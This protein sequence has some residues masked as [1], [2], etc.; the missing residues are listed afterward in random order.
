MGSKQ[1]LLTLAVVLVAVFSLFNG[2]G[3]TKQWPQSLLSA[4]FNFLSQNATA[5]P[6]SYIRDSFSYTGDASANKAVNQEPLNIVLLYADDWTMKVLGKLNPQVLTPNID[7]MADKGI[8]FTQNCVTTS[9]CWVSRAT[10]MTGLYAVRHGQ[11]KLK[12]DHIFK[13]HPWSQTLFPLLRNEGYYTGL[14]GKWHGLKPDKYMKKAFDFQVLYHGTHWMKRNG[15]TRHVTDLNLEDSMKFLK[16][17]PKDKKFA[18]K[19]SFFA[20]H[21]EKPGIFPSYQPMKSNR[22]E[23]TTIPFP[24]T[25]TDRHWKD[26][27]NFFTKSNEGRK[28][29]QKRFEHKHYNESIK[30]LYKMAS[31]VDDV[32][33]KII[34]E[35]KDQGVYDSTML[36]FTTDN[37]NLHGEHGLA[38][39]WYPFEESIRVPLVIQDPRMPHSKRGTVSEHFT[40]NIDLAPT[41]LGAAKI[42]AS[43]FMQGRDISSLYLERGDLEPWREDFFYEH[44]IGADPIT[45]KGFLDKKNKVNIP[46]SLALVTKEWKYIYWPQYKHEQLFHRSL[47]PYDERDLLNLSSVQTT[48]QIYVDMKARYQLLKDLVQNGSKA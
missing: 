5:D 40:L 44:T 13:R 32:V 31:E 45:G 34:Q 46:A 28:R 20:T 26:L 42:A 15:K 22:Y 2:N 16:N 4:S 3:I 19:V 30:N 39:K 27:P 43:S 48:D 36:L 41:L 35:L 7:E 33:G 47:D 38:E 6:V 1:W 14:V 25:N 9:I 24:M 12:Y 29:Y 23:N 10:L 8:L 17:R 18:L 21:A 11:M 37:G